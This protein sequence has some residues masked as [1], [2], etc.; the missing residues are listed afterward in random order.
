VWSISV[1]RRFILHGTHQ[2]NQVTAP[3]A[4]QNQLRINNELVVLE[5]LTGNPY[6][7]LSE[8]QEWRCSLIEGGF[9]IEIVS[10]G[11]VSSSSQRSTPHRLRGSNC[12][13]SGKIPKEF[14]GGPD[15]SPGTESLVSASTTV[16]KRLELTIF[17]IK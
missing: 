3:R 4:S 10:G 13:G 16:N 12:V 6:G 15:A 11:D 17:D 1:C 2:M 9:G 5:G 7:H 14:P 8:M